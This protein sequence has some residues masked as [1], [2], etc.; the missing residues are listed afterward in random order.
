MHNINKAHK[1]KFIPDLW[2][3][4]IKIILKYIHNFECGWVIKIKISDTTKQMIKNMVFVSLV[5]LILVCFVKTFLPYILGLT[6]GTLLAIAKLIL[7]EQSID[8]SLNMSPKTAEKYIHAQYVLRYILTGL[9][10]FFV[11]KSRSISTI[12][13]LIGLCSLQISAYITGFKKK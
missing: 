4:C 12:G 13:F 1:M 9:V 2:F 6:I 8:K 10:L 3:Y 5:A 11:I 7:M